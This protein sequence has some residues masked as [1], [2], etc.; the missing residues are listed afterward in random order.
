MRKPVRL[1]RYRLEHHRRDLTPLIL[2]TAETLDRAQGLLPDLVARLAVHSL[3]GEVRVISR[4][5]DPEITIA[6]RDAPDAFRFGDEPT[7]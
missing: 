7:P 6:I 4:A 1:P 2:A 3:C 5:H